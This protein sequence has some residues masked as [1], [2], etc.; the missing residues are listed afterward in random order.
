MRRP[1]GAGQPQ[2][3][4]E[5]VVGKEPETGAERHSEGSREQA[6]DTMS[7]CHWGS[8]LPRTM[9]TGR[10]RPRCWRSTAWDF[11]R[12]A[13][14]GFTEDMARDVWDA[15]SVGWAGLRGLGEALPFGEFQE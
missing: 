7:W 11:H 6:R 2:R 14:P 13:A 4:E 3:V 12:T 1:L 5:Q 9:A 8:V 15:S 10:G